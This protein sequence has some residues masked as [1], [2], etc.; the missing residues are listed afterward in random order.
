MIER[1]KL[2]IR[3]VKEFQQYI[4]TLDGPVRITVRKESKDRSSIQ[5]RY[6]W[7]VVVAL[8]S[9]YTG[10]FKHETHEVL[11]WMF[12]KDMQ[13]FNGKIYEF[14]TSTTDLTT[15]EFEEYQSS[16]RTWASAELNLY[17]PKPNECDF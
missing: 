14:S 15:A 17:I 3:N 11:K 8:I 10:F 7:G 13:V 1:G 12:L 9:D 6:Y 16:I 5:N 4:A 2:L